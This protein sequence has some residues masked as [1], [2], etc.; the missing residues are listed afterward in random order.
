MECL[1]P[2]EQRPLATVDT[3]AAFAMFAVPGQPILDNDDIQALRD[4]YKVPDTD[5]RIHEFTRRHN[6]LHTTYNRFA[7]QANSQDPVTRS[8]VHLTFKHFKAALLDMLKAMV[9]NGPTMQELRNNPNIELS[10]VFGEPTP[11]AGA[12][13]DKLNMLMM[14]PEN[15]VPR[16]HGLH[17]LR[18]TYFNLMDV[19]MVHDMYN[20]FAA[21]LEA[22]T[23]VAVQRRINDWFDD[24]NM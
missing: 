21:I 9:H 14:I 17:G 2:N 13:F 5:M 22:P 24:D 11:M 15:F 18:V 10:T 6:K 20:V 1:Y 23:G 3:S 4:S 8:L 7:S 16:Q 12:L 19:N